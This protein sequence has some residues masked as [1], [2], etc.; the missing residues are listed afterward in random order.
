LVKY[1][2]ISRKIIERIQSGD[3]MPGMRIPS[4][5]EIISHYEVSSTTARKALNE[6]EQ[7]GYATKIKGKGTFV[8]VRNVERTVTRILG[9]SKNMRQ[10]GHAPSTKVLD[11]KIIRSGYAA[12]INGRWY[13]MKGPVQKIRRL[14]FADGIPMML[15]ER[16]I[17]T[18]LCPDI[19]EKELEGSLYDI[20]EKT[21]GLQ[22]TEVNQMLSAQVISD[23]KTQALFDLDQEIPAFLVNG[24]TFCARETI[25]EME[26]SIYRGDKYSFS[27]K[28]TQGQ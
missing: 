9:F 4:E 2:N 24:V 13:S 20:Y 21:Y 25:L 18:E 27:V 26:E 23:K 6:L 14:R 19:E 17:S 15:E 12:T 16:F 5:N 1:L 3:L 28:A 10:A 8:L 22:L 7:S 11:S